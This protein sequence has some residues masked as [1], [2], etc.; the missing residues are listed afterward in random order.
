MRELF[1]L[2]LAIVIMTIM[3]TT[4]ATIIVLFPFF[5]PS[6]LIAVCWHLCSQSRSATTM[7][8]IVANCR[9]WAIHG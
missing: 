5:V 9:E 4:I 7:R 8:T 3:T 2:L 6:F 1:P